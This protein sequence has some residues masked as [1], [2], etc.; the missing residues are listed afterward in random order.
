MAFP[1]PLFTNK[2]SGQFLFEISFSFYRY[3]CKI[4][5][6]IA[7]GVSQK[8]LQWSLEEKCLRYTI[9]F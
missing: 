2:R 5:Y 6:T 8:R 3:E 4:E 1:N 9:F 7:H